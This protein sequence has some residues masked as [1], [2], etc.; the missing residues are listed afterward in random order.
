[1]QTR[2]T[3]LRDLLTA[4][5]VPHTPDYTDSQFREMPFKTVFGLSKV[6]KRYSIDCEAIAL[7]SKEQYA[8][9]PTPF[10]AQ[11]SGRFIVVTSYDDHKVTYIEGLAQHTVSTK[12]FLDI[13]TG[14]VVMAYPNES[15]CEPSYRLH[16]NVRL[17]ISSKKWIALATIIFLAAY[18]IV[19]RHIYLYPSLLVLTVIDIIGL[20]ASILLVR[21][22]IGFTDKT[23]EKVCGVL[24]SGGC[25]D[26]M[27]TAA[28][29][30]Y[31]IFGWSEVGFAYFS[32]SLVTMLLFPSCW[33]Y[34]ALI[35]IFC[36]PYTLWS[37]W[38]QHWRAHTWCTLCVTVQCMLWC[39]FFCYLAG[40]WY[41][42]A[43]P[44]GWPIVALIATY[45]A[46]LLGLNAVIPIMTQTKQS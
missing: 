43:F 22:E 6:L 26:I 45:I 13:A 42:A 30:F 11:V 14:I 2:P 24:R 27:K 15:S 8:Q 20:L 10:I 31:G 37:I 7:G 23:A 33:G 18:L 12:R 21:K 46:V 5:E 4:L 38:Y 28:S 39:Q 34:L 29:K 17:A 44:L 19:T 1:M 35:N 25:D 36:L 32:V 40:D 9:L 3:L 16:R 41:K